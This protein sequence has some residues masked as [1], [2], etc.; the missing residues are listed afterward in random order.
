M[1][2]KIYSFAA[3]LTI[4]ASSAGMLP[5]SGT[6]P[7]ISASAAEENVLAALPSRV[8]LSADESTR[9]FFPEIDTQ[10]SYNACCSYSSTYYQFTYE[11]RK[12]FYEKYGY[13]SNIIFSPG[14]TFNH[15]NGGENEGTDLNAA[16]ASLTINGVLFDSDSAYRAEDGFVVGKLETSPE[17]LCKALKARL[18]QAYPIYTDDCSEDEAIIRMKEQLARGKAITTGGLFD[19]D[20][21]YGDSNFKVPIKGRNGEYAYVMN[22]TPKIDNPPV[23]AYTIVGYDDDITVTYEGKTLT[24][25][26]KIANS[27]GKDW[28][29][30]GFMWIMYDACYQYSP[31]NIDCA[32]Y[33]RTRTRAFPD[34]H[35][36][37][38]DVDIEGVKLIAEADIDT[39]ALEDVVIRTVS[40]NNGTSDSVTD[41]IRNVDD[42]K[43]YGYKG[44]VVKEIS[45]CGDDYYT[46]NSYEIN[47]ISKPFSNS[48]IK[49]NS[50][51]VRDDLGNVV[52]EKA[53]K[54][55][56]KGGVISL[57][58]QKGDVNYDG[59]LDKKDAELIRDFTVG[60]AYS[61]LQK[62]LMD[63]NND[64]EITAEDAV[65]AES[66]I[67]AVYWTEDGKFK[68]QEGVVYTG[69]HLINDDYYYLDENGFRTTN[70]FIDD[71]NKGETYYVD[72]NGRALSDSWFM[73]GGKRYYAD[74]NGYVI[75]NCE[76]T[77]KGTSRTFC[78]DENGAEVLGWNADHTKYYS[79]AGMFIGSHIIDGESFFF[80]NN[81]FLVEE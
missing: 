47:V 68:G 24:G 60:K 26:F 33:N 64:G 57:D 58:L 41:I 69:W 12:A 51:S 34:D 42:L 19:Y 14:F 2:K 66:F 55:G 48:S 10:A 49:V 52:A 61:T 31:N 25:A 16:Y 40:V 76:Y 38:I 21:M 80:D 9:Q 72:E 71:D 30:D 20:C 32:K 5:F 35:F 13:C 27:W 4:T 46:G 75:K 8:D 63:F 50:I 6:A 81:G 70:S 67:E 18:K 29:N 37:V 1:F 17:L 78:F 53:M 79:T 73:I 36:Y 39:D 44:S 15:V 62:D 28:G 59:I 77:I 54:N 56:E 45:T 74:E 43:N 11:A 3:A 22:A 7:V 65:I 23:H